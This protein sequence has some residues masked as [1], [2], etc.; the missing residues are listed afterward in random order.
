MDI[1]SCCAITFPLVAV[2]G[3]EDMCSIINTELL[4]IGTF[5]IDASGS[6]RQL[7]ASA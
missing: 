3:P 7:N 1:G 4:G 5:N 2:R 6:G